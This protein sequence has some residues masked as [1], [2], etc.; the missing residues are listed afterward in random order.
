MVEWARHGGGSRIP[1]DVYI[2]LSLSIYI[3]SPPPKW[4]YLFTYIFKASI[5]EDSRIPADVY[6]SSYILIHVY[7]FSYV[8]ACFLY[9]FVY[10]FGFSSY[11][12]DRSSIEAIHD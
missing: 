10:I 3:W 5:L 12:I 1:A 11:K 7:T 8:F 4:T 2:S 6:I 9:V